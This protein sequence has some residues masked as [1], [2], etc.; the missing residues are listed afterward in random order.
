L[1]AK[2]YSQRYGL[3]RRARYFLLTFLEAWAV[4]ALAARSSWAHNVSHGIITCEALE[5][6]LLQFVALAANEKGFVTLV[7]A[8]CLNARRAWIDGDLEKDIPFRRLFQIRRPATTAELL[9]WSF[10]GRAL[11]YPPKE[12]LPP[13]VQDQNARLTTPEIPFIG[14]DRYTAASF[15]RW[16]ARWIG[17]LRPDLDSIGITSPSACL[18]RSRAEGGRLAVYREMAEEALGPRKWKAIKEGS[19]NPSPRVLA[20]EVT[21]SILASI[22]KNRYPTGSV[23]MPLKEL[24]YKVR[25][26][27]KSSA[28]RLAISEAF[29]VPLLAKLSK[30]RAIGLPLRGEEQRL[31]IRLPPTW[32]SSESS[33]KRRDQLVV[34]SADLTA[35]TDYLRMSLIVA[36]ARAVGIPEDLIS[37]GTIDGLVIQ[38][39]TLMGIPCSWPTLSAVHF[40]FCI[41]IGA[42]PKTFYM[43]GDDLMALW[44]RWLV[45]RYHKLLGPVTG[46]PP[47]IQKSF[48]STNHHLRGVFCEKGYQFS[49]TDSSFLIEGTFVSV[50]ALSSADEGWVTRSAKQNWAL[51]MKRRPGQ[52]PGVPP[53]FGAAQYLRGQLERIGHRQAATLCEL[54]SKETISQAKRNRMVMYLPVELGGVG[55]IP[56][57]SGYR[58]PPPISAALTGYANGVP[59]CQKFFRGLATAGLEDESLEKKVSERVGIL[60]DLAVYKLDHG[61]P[62]LELVEDEMRSAHMILDAVRGFNSTPP[63]VGLKAFRRSFR[64]N[65]K[66]IGKLHPMADPIPV[67]WRQANSLSSRMVGSLP[68]ERFTVA[69]LR[70]RPSWVLDRAVKDLNSKLPKEL[71]YEPSFE[72]VHITCGQRSSLTWGTLSQLA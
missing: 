53:S 72:P 41:M 55:L 54:V 52:H 49:R 35:A 50:R 66:T 20:T 62:W 47:N 10:L 37:G 57:K 48:V 58:F 26:V 4:T 6:R 36:L 13:A 68:E 32:V 65:S 30:L 39:G 24:G 18:E 5:H 59:A 27:S 38:M 45:N 63:E 28:K 61:L 44:P 71:R 46:M 15:G 16:C 60:T 14:E 31:P 21:L 33:G 3:S 51:S 29:R 69:H 8:F 42:P 70:S 43:K 56:R 67:S 22:K 17:K 2:W 7:K 9:Q 12:A 40:W 64:T 1:R 25:V 19:S 23:S 11:P 34:L